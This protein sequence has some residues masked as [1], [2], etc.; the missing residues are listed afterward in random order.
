[1]KT[2][3]YDSNGPGNQ[4]GFRG[5]GSAWWVTSNPDRPWD[6]HFG[7]FDIS[8]PLYWALFHLGIID[9]FA[10]LP[11]D[12]LLGSHEEGILK[13]SGL[14][15]AV[16]LL[17]RKA[18]SLTESTYEWGCTKQFSPERI[19]YKIRVDAAKLK[20]ELLAL[21]DFLTEAASQGL[22]VQLWL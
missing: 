12:G 9:D 4:P 1:M 22:D 18:E 2:I 3:Y 21:E 7:E 17:R 10:E 11:Y 6:E 20:Q 8:E 15:S 14:Q 5:G 16:E 19:E 13:S